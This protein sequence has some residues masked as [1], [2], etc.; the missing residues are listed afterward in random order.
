ML[1]KTH[2]K[3]IM[4]ALAPWDMQLLSELFLFCCLDVQEATSLS[5]QFTTNDF[6]KKLQLSG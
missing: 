3:L 2:G 5:L 4:V 1:V 6:A